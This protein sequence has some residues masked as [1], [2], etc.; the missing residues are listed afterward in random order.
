M[1][2]I[3]AAKVLFCVLVSLLELQDIYIYITYLYRVT[4]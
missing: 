1:F 2:V 4:T 3:N